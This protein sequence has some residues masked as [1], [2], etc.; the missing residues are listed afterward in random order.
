MDHNYS[1]FF[2]AGVVAKQKKKKNSN[3]Q[4]CTGESNDPRRVLE[5]MINISVTFTNT[6]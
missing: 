3:K 5:T 4:K 2:A 1:L 6:V